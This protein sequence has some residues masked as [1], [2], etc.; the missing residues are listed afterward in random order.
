M[1][2]DDLEI[3]ASLKRTDAKP[4]NGQPKAPPPPVG[5]D[6][7]PATDAKPAPKVTKVPTGMTGKKAAA[8]AKKAAKLPPMFKGREGL[9]AVADIAKE[10][11]LAPRDA[12][13]ILRAAKLKKPAVGWAYDAKDPALKRV[14]ELLKAG[15]A[16]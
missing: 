2:N 14:R 10:Y 9:V 5:N 13:A 6:A 12:R 7:K 15:K 16:K 4:S 3:P 11:K 8:Q 1:K